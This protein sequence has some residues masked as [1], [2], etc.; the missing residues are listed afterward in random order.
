MPPAAPET[1]P[2]AWSNQSHFEI[3]ASPLALSRMPSMLTSRASGAMSAPV[4]RA[5]RA[6]GGLVRGVE[7]VERGLDLRLQLQPPDVDLHGVSRR[8]RAP[9]QQPPAGRHG[10][11]VGDV[12]VPR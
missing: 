2:P 11:V 3:V 9:R 5:D 8:Q 12:E 10:P 7:L 1:S 4:R 6:C